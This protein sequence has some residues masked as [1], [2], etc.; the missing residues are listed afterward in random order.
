MSLT[1]K[2]VIVTG[3]AGGLGKTIADAFLE[4]GAN[5][6]VADVNSQRLAS[7]DDEYTRS[8]ADRFL[9]HKADVTSE[10]QVQ[11]L[12]DATV[13][14]F[15]RLDVLVNNAGIMDD[16]SPAGTCSREQWDRVLAINLTGPF[17]TTKTAVAQFLKQQHEGAGTG[18]IIN[19]GSNAS[20]HGF[21]A[22]VAYTVSK[23]GLLG[24]TRNTAS[25]YG[26]RGISCVTLLLGGMP[27]TN[28]LEGLAGGVQSLDME[29][30]QMMEATRSKLTPDRFTSTKGVAK[31]CV[32]LA[33]P[34]VSPTAN[35]SCITFNNNWPEA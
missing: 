14:K 35:G 30:M 33:D 2:T 7:V 27:G 34:D 23:T 4:A 24:L 5:V 3:A 9:T 6:V 15:G 20:V 17:L 19:I 31:Y 12:V 26:T 28:I 32:F 10:A 13:A 16:F 22:G 11:G 8:F 29:M 25:S 1:A 18:L 21:Q